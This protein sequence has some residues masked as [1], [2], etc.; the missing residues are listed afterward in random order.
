MS[1]NNKTI[2]S[3][4]G[5]RQTAAMCVAVVRGLLPRPDHIVIADTGRESSSTWDYLNNV[6]QPYLSKVGLCVE[7][8]SHDL[9][10]VDLYARNGDLL[11]P[12]YTSDGKLPTFC[13]NEW[14]KFVVH[15]YIRKTLG[16][17]ECEMW[18]GYSTDEMRRMH[19]S[20]LQWLEH[21][22]PLIDVLRWSA[23][24]CVSIVE[25]EGLPTPPK[26]AC[27]CCPH[28]KPHQ[29]HEMREQRPDDFAKAVEL[30]EQIR[31]QDIHKDVYLFSGRIPLRLAELKPA[32]EEPNL[33]TACESGY[34]YT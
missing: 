14:K 16:V 6:M 32:E 2:L 33:F 13:A 25:D 28:W 1:N 22:F 20:R 5:G 12:A 27:W 21:R 31:E 15:R 8:A 29:W 19:M 24:R 26:S 9:A 4:G 34:C 23:A 7:I 30:D 11:I 3:Y 10:T 17:S 18:L